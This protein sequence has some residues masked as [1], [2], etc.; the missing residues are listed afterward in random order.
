MGEKFKDEEINKRAT[1]ISKIGGC[2]ESY[3]NL[4]TN[5]Q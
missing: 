2:Q 1:A 5:A 4:R 3:S